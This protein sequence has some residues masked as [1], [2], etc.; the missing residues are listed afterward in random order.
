MVE[1]NEVRKLIVVCFRLSTIY[2]DNIFQP[3]MDFREV[4][5]EIKNLIHPIADA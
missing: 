3:S 5:R 4:F 2:G 1:L